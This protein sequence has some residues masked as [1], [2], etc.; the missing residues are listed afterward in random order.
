MKY[1]PLT[2]KLFWKEGDKIEAEAIIK[3]YLKKVAKEICWMFPV[4]RIYKALGL[5]SE[6][7]ERCSQCEDENRK[8]IHTCGKGDYFT[9]PK[10]QQES[11][12]LWTCPKCNDVFISKWQFCPIDGEPRPAEPKP[13]R[14]R[15]A[16]EPLNTNIEYRNYPNDTWQAQTG[17]IKAKLNEVISFLNQES[18]KKG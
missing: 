5:S 7:E 15:L 3:D 8:G 12:G 9:T 6:K 18:E 1:H 13:L 17:S 16:I 2:D 10:P 4:P 14:E 11:G